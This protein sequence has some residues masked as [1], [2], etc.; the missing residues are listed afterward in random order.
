MATEKEIIA[1]FEKIQADIPGF[2][3]ASMV[4]LDSGIW[5]W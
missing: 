4:D 5:R 3:A 2:I 1:I